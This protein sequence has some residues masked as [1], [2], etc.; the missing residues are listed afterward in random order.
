MEQT[1]VDI[2]N[3]LLGEHMDDEYLGSTDRLEAFLEFYEITRNKKHSPEGKVFLSACC[4]YIFSEVIQ[5]LNDYHRDM[6]QSAYVNCIMNTIECWRADDTANFELSMKCCLAL[7]RVWLDRVQETASDNE[8]S[9]VRIITSTLCL[10][11]A[12]PDYALLMYACK[13]VELVVP[14]V[15]RFANILYT[16]TRNVIEFIL[17]LSCP[18]ALPEEEDEPLPNVIVRNAYEHGWPDMYAREAMECVTLLELKGFRLNWEPI[19][20]LRNFV[21]RLRGEAEEIEEEAGEAG[22]AEEIEEEEEEEEEGE[23]EID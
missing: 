18:M 7:L 19:E 12:N 4:S 6:L 16:P 8:K 14:H 2:V 21:D 3:I 22:E 11:V 15:W 13:H 5:N 1:L 10:F 9:T 17:S 20:N 23:E